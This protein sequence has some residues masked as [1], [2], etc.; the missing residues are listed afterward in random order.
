VKES[1]LALLI[2][3]GGT[4]NLGEKSPYFLGGLRIETKDFRLEGTYD[5]SDKIESPGYRISGL[6]TW[7]YHWLRFGGAYSYRS[8]K[9][10]NKSAPFL[11]LGIGS[12]RVEL[13]LH[14]A[15]DTPNNELKLTLKIKVWKLELHSLYEYYNMT[16]DSSDRR[17]GIGSQLVLV[18]P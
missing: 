9:A 3:I 7:S 11:V 6:S 8:T 4:S 16:N 10:W 15:I 17:F 12:E 5:T 13:L 1:I 18:L 2:G 14:K